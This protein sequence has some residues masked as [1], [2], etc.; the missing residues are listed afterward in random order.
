MSTACDSHDRQIRQLVGSASSKHSARLALV[1]ANSRSSH[2]AS[3]IRGE[4]PTFCVATLSELRAALNTKECHSE[5]GA[6]AVDEIGG[7]RV[8]AIDLTDLALSDTACFA[9]HLNS[10]S[11][12][13]VLFIVSPEQFNLFEEGS[14]DFVVR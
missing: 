13:C 10:D 2:S 9:R 4:L 12:D 8:I 14:F 7:D 11:A 1:V 5:Q 6:S 3:M